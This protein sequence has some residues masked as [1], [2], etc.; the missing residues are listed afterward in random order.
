MGEVIDPIKSENLPRGRSPL[1][2]KS[3]KLPGE[4]STLPVGHKTIRGEVNLVGGA[5]K[6]SGERLTLPVGQEKSWGRI[7][8]ASGP[9][10]SRVSEYYRKQMAK[11]L[12]FILLFCQSII[13]TSS[14]SNSLNKSFV[15][16]L[17]KKFSRPA[18]F[19]V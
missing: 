4:G 15:Y 6:S 3:K 17:F 12:L 2:I 11:K 18:I 16:H 1:P 8:P 10:K 19:N 5:Q 7:E 9:I 13:G 14:L